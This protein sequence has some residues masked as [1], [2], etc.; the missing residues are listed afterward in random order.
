MGCIDGVACLRRVSSVA[1]D[2]NKF[3]SV[4]TGE[5]FVSEFIKSRIMLSR[6]SSDIVDV[7]PLE[8]MYVCV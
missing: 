4:F 3:C 6:N 8:F 7:R 5:L 2:F 1:Y